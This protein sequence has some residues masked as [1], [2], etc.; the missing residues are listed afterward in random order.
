MFT[1]GTAP[2]SVQR[3]NFITINDDAFIEPDETF[4]ITFE[5]I[6]ILQGDSLNFGIGGIFETIVTILDQDSKL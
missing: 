5:P 2:K 4:R 3:Q 6:D 1:V